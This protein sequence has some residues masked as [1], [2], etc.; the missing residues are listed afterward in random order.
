MFIGLPIRGIHLV[1]PSAQNASSFPVHDAQFW[2][3]G[4]DGLSDPDD[5]GMIMPG[6][7]GLNGK[8]MRYEEAVERT[9]LTFR[10]AEGI[11]WIRRADGTLQEQTRPTAR[12]SI[13]AAPGRSLPVPTEPAST[14]GPAGRAEEPEAPG[15]Q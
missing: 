1:Q 11:R 7:V 14:A 2:Y 12:E 9:I 13:L 10:D 5:L 15:A 8:Q 4:P 3:Y 6:S